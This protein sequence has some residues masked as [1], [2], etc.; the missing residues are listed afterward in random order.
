MGMTIDNCGNIFEVPMKVTIDKCCTG[1]D[2]YTKEE[3]MAMLTE[4]QLEIDEMP[5]H[6]DP[7]DVSD[8]IQDKINTL[9]G[10]KDV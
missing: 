4:I 8:L 7:R 9:E 10:N 1:R 3:V 6:Y 5:M 2:G